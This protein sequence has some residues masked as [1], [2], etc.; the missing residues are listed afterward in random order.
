MNTYETNNFRLKYYIHAATQRINIVWNT[1]RIYK[2]GYFCTFV[3]SKQ[4]SYFEVLQGKG[5]RATAKPLRILS[6]CMVTSKRDQP[7]QKTHE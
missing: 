4:K 5:L 3:Q 7:G 1:D 2:T 6:D